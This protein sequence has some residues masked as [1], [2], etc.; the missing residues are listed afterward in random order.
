MHHPKDNQ[1]SFRVNV[2]DEVVMMEKKQVCHGNALERVL[3][4]AQG[5]F[6]E[7][8]EKEIEEC[9]RNLDSSKEVH[10]KDA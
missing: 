8:E 1:Q 9:L 3:I 5:D 6:L 2:L 10:T 4:E 7:E